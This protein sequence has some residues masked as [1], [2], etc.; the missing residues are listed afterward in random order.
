MKA[1][2]VVHF[3]MPY[4]DHERVM[5]FYS[6]AFG[7][8]MKKLGSDMSDYVLAGTTEMDE[9]MMIKTPGNINGGF[10]KPDAANPAV[11]SVVISVGNIKESI[12]KVSDTGGKIFGE[13]VEIPSI[14]LYV[15]FTDSEGNRVG[16]L[17]PPKQ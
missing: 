4:K 8:Q 13:P 1:D 7:W 10:Y 11:P 17:Q 3:E 6:K 5:S 2:P 16:M 15:S 12:K 14:G 9:N